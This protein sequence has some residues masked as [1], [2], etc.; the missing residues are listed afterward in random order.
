MP[1]AGR[2]FYFSPQY[3]FTMKNLILVSLLAFLANLVLPS[4]GFSQN[5][6]TFKVQR[7]KKATDLLNEQDYAEVV[8][9]QVLPIF[10]VR[11]SLGNILPK[12]P[13]LEDF[14]EKTYPLVSTSVHPFVATL[15][16]A[17]AE[18]RPVVI[19]PDMIWLMIAQGVSLHI[20]QNSE[21]MRELFV[22]FEG[23][24]NLNV[25]RDDFIIG[26]RL[27]DWEGAIIGLRGNMGIYTGHEWTE[28][29]SPTF[30]TTTS[31]EQAAF[32]ITLMDA[33][34]EYFSYSVTI[35]CGIPEITLEGTPEDWQE[36]ERRVK[37][38]KKYGLDWW[39]ADLEP[40]LHQFVE[41]SEGNVKKKFWSEIFQ[42]ESYPSGC[43]TV[44]YVSG[45]VTKFFPYVKTGLDSYYKNPVMVGLPEGEYMDRI[46]LKNKKGNYQ[47]TFDQFPSGMSRV[48]VFINNLWDYMIFEFYGGFMGI[49][50][51]HETLALRPEIGWAIVDTGRKP[52][53]EEIDQYKKPNSPGKARVSLTEDE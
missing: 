19:S 37:E 4:Y 5:Q 28:L 41:A 36:I 39:I 23:K 42:V 11:D 33:M 15:S 53:Q 17:Y 46:F 29:M 26:T 34:K 1:E 47:L 25:R 31:I 51:N 22:D 13:K 12:Q 10:P 52:T 44:D 40:V 24:E 20:N 50:Q 49:H 48:E 35:M 14:S 43:T 30:S 18:H 6:I 9:E 3:A 38:F 27:N 21:E 2:Y 8:A 45:W 16:L 7:V 32:D